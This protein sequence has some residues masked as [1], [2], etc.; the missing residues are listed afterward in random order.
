MYAQGI[1][2][3][4]PYLRDPYAK[5]R[6]VSFVTFIYLFSVTCFT[7]NTFVFRNIILT[8]KVDKGICHGKLGTFRGIIQPQKP[9]DVSPSR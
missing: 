4:F 9:V 3:L 7:V 5:H 2:G 8:L 1:I 6:Y